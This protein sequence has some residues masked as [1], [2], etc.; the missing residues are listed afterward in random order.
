[1]TDLESRLDEALKAD[2]PPPRDPMFRIAVMVRRERA[3][4]RR[5][6][7]AGCGLAFGAAILAALGMQVLQV[8]PDAER[9]TAGVVAGAVLA[10]LLAAPW[11]GGAP[12]LRGLLARASSVYRTIPGLRLWP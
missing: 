4:L 3:A 9:L 5:R 7:L 12:S 10:A 6:L 8:V 2:G 1:M 11:L